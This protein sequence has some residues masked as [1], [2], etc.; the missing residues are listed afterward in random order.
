MHLV[1]WIFI[2]GHVLLVFFFLPSAIEKYKEIN[3]VQKKKKEISAAKLAEWDARKVKE[4]REWKSIKQ[5]AAETAK[6]IEREATE[7][8]TK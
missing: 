8:K 2:G 4:D 5:E 7:S 1:T 3:E 6:R